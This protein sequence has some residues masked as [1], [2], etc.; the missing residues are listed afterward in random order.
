VVKPVDS[1]PG[2][3]KFIT[4]LWSVDQIA[5]I[6]ITHEVNRFDFCKSLVSSTSLLLT[7]QNCSNA[8]KTLTLQVGKSY[9]LD[10]SE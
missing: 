8:P 3:L 4:T 9:P 1:H 2:Q 6:I 5:Q 7:V 10:D